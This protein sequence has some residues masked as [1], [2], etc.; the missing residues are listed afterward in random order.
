[1]KGLEEH[2]AIYVL[3]ITHIVFHDIYCSETNHTIHTI[4][5][6]RYIPYLSA[7]IYLQ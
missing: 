4:L 6:R 5:S 1:M 3:K 2:S 7:K